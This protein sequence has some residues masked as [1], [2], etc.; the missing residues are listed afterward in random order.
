MAHKPTH[1]DLRNDDRPLPPRSP[2][3]GAHLDLPSP[4]AGEVPPALSPL[5][6]FAL[7]SRMLAQ[8]FEESEKNGRRISRLPFSTVERE[9]ANRPGYFRSFSENSEASEASETPKPEEPSNHGQMGGD[10]D[11]DRP[12]S[13]YPTFDFAR[14]D[15]TITPL[16]PAREED[17]MEEQPARQSEDYFGAPRASSPEPVDPK[18]IGVGLPSPNVPSLTGS[19]DSM[20]SSHP[21]TLTNGSTQSQRSERG[22]LAPKS[23]AYPRSPRSFQSIRSVRQDSGDEDSN[24][25]PPPVLPSGARKFSGS[26][27]ISRPQSPYSTFT[28]PVQRSPSV[29]SEENSINGSQTLQR[30]AFNFS[31]PLSSAGNRPSNDTRPSFDARPSFDSRR[32]SHDSRDRYPSNATNTTYPSTASIPPSRQGSGE[33]VPRLATSNLQRSETMASDSTADETRNPAPTYTHTKFTL[34]RGRALDRNSVNASSWIEHQFEKA[35]QDPLIASN[36]KPPPVK[37]HDTDDSLRSLPARPASPA[38]SV[39]AAHDTARLGRERGIS[40]ATRSRSADPRGSSTH[41][42]QLP[43]FPS[44]HKQP[45]HKKSTPSI[46]TASTDRTIRPSNNKVPLHARSASA[47]LSP[48]EHLE[49]GIASHTAGNVTKSTYHLRLAARAGL[50]TAMLLYALA[51]RHGW[52]MRPNQEEGVLWLRRAIDSSGLEDRAVEATLQNVA[53]ERQAGDVLAADKEKRERKASMAL[54]VYELGISYMNG[55]GCG[56]DRSLALRCFELA[57]SWGDCDALAEAGFCYVQ[58]LGCRVDKKKAAGFYR[59]AAEGGMS[60][61]GNSW[62][63]KPKY[64]DDAN[65]STA[66]SKKSKDKSDK[67]KQSSNESAAAS[68]QKTPGR[69]RARSLWSRKKSS[70][71]D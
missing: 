9:M 62:I 28:Q 24:W 6:A 45:E 61:A 8:Q 33:E 44:T 22:L 42:T 16:S 50:P 13:Y 12:V 51:C 59:R 1:L 10:E 40:S 43:N 41:A 30:P 36:Q 54:A 14:Q 27:N 48:E 11:K 64:M 63:Y 3:G 20:P 32:P 29:T 39:K 67:I 49:I 58:G 57:G 47:D 37:R 71:V 18:S 53:L 60:M 26:S 69:S 55:W 31:R 7:R 5:D 19:M 15:N 46:Q 4:R 70:A 66:S 23:P 65:A 34:P 38:T 25:N 52:G 17:E 68:G 21:R 2:R 56:K 35:G